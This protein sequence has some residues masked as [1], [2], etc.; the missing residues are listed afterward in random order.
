MTGSKSVSEADLRA[1][2]IRL[3][4][5]GG[6]LVAFLLT[7][8][9]GERLSRPLFDSWQRFAPRDLAATQVHAVLIDSESLAAVGPWPWPR[10]HLARLTEEIAARGAVAIGF[11]MI[12][13]EPD[14][15]RPDI[16]A[17]LY[18]ELSPAA[19]A[20]VTRLEPMD[21]LFGK[22]IGRSPA[23]LGR[24]AVTEGGVVADDL[25]VEAIFGGA[26]PPDIPSSPRA[27]A[28][29]PEL[30]Q[31]ALGHGLL[32]G[33]P[34]GDG[35]VRRV[36]LMMKVGARPMPGFALE[37]ART[38]AGVDRVEAESGAIRLGARRIPVDDQGR[39]MV[40]FGNLPPSAITS[41]AN[42]F[43][44]N[45]DANAFAGKIVLLGLAAEGTADIVAT[46]LAAEGFGTLVQA[47]AV[48]AIM[49]GGWLDRPGWAI[50][51]EWGAG[52]VLA[53]II[54]LLAPHRRRGGV[55]VPLALAAA[56]VV[57]AWFSFDAAS[58]LIDPI[59]PLILG[60]SAAA[61]VIAGIF[62]ETRR[63]R[64]R[65]R[66][67]L[68]LE[69]IAA[70]ESEGELQAART[71]QLGMLPTRDSLAALDPRVD[72]DARLEPAKSVGGDFFDVVRLD[73]D[74]I[75]FAIGDVT[76]KGVPAALFM[77]LSKALTKSV[78]LRETSSL[79]HAAV[80]LNAELSRD[81]SD[82]MGVTMLL[83]LL[84]LRDGAVAL[85]SAGHEHPFHVRSDGTVGQ[86][87]LEGGPPFCILDFPYP[88]EAMTLAPG[89]TLI[90]VTDGVTEAQNAAGGLFG[91]ERTLEAARSPRAR[92]A[93]ESV[94]AIMKAVRQFEDGA[95]A[96]DDL[97]VMAIRYIG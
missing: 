83:G 72:I 88:A 54:L 92:T 65:L 80:M 11:D 3:A 66:D 52:V 91:V 75:G 53:F 23:V 20:E 59:R 33:P 26:P 96:S 76:G 86:H 45:F 41:A 16:F 44:Q 46:P 81:E 56:I 73:A 40:R 69:R 6:L 27:I 93:P 47:Q 82:T 28:N 78:M 77:A 39:M 35:A 22:V 32:N 60:G 36:P 1:R 85:V 7:L 49:R 50:A 12:F 18:P 4:G 29:I 74:R 89:E 13:A 30:E 70:A 17:S 79:G 34:D 87:P 57:A 62:A 19:A 95:D 5:L 61:G 64:E 38:A 63:E 9:L 84:D 71:I 90:L 42:V 14:R 2:R 21:Q 31:V 94:N 68:V 10:Y 97:T 8:A 43:R 58:L 24:A 48:D 25:P 37:I 15:V 51:A 55:A 67:A